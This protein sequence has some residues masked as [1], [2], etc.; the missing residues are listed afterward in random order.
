MKIKY[1]YIALG[2]FIIAIACESTKIQTSGETIILKKYEFS[3]VFP[4][5]CK[6]GC[7]EPNSGYKFLVLW[8][9]FPDSLARQDVLNQ[10]VDG[11]V[12]VK[13]GDVIIK[14]IYVSDNSDGARSN[15]YYTGI[16]HGDL[17]LAF[18]VY[19]KSNGFELNWSKNKPILIE[20]KPPIINRIYKSILWSN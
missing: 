16:F 7:K 18:Q 9:K 20:N 11:H 2:F 8:L 14:D 4:P 6:I 13:G 1:V 17:V 10:L 12:K 3:D 15:V 19:Y 5:D